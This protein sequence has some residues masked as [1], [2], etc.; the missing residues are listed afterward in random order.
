ML[1]RSLISCVFVVDLHVSCAF[2]GY[3][4]YIVVVYVAASDGYGYYDVYD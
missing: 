4:G 3:F 2:R 1:S